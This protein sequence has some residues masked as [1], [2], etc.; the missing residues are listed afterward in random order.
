MLVDTW[1]LELRSG[2]LCHI[3]RP[4]GPLNILAE[5]NG[6]GGFRGCIRYN[7]PTFNHIRKDADQYHAVKTITLCQNH[8]RSI[9]ICKVGNPDDFMQISTA[10]D[11]EKG[12]YKSNQYI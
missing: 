1:S 2:A 8:Q 4:S 6:S 12:A 11:A 5:K 10:Y 7:V 9:K 3:H